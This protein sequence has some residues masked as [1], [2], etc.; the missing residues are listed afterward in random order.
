MFRLRSK[1]RMILFIIGV[2]SFAIEEMQLFLSV[3]HANVRML[4][5][6]RIQRR[7]PAL[8]RPANY[9]INAHLV[10]FCHVAR[11]RDISKCF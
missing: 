4:P 1:I 5:Q 3:R 6:K 2:V 9:E 10:L 11:S 7:R 8:L